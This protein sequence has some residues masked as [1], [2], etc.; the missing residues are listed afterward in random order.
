MLMADDTRRSPISGTAKILQ[1]NTTQT[2]HVIGTPSYMS[3]EQI[4][5]KPV[6][7]R[8]DVFSLS[9][10]SYTNFSQARSRFRGNQ[11]HR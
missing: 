3:P 2:A 11:S 5:G 9:A 8:T 6:D 4:K 7:G 10:S 1:L